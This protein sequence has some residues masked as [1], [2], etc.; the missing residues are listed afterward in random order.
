MVV[1][2]ATTIIQ[3]AI[4][5][6][7]LDFICIVKTLIETNVLVFCTLCTFFVLILV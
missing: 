1:S 2:M 6:K 3:C 4:E 7:N 5:F